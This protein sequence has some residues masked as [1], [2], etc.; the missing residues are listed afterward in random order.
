MPYVVVAV[1]YLVLAALLGTHC[2]D[3]LI[4]AISGQDIAFVGDL[5]LAVI[6][7]SAAIPLA[8]AF[9]LVS[10]FGLVY[11]LMQATGG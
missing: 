6:F 5:V 10:L 11:P 4:W 8:L 9:W 1:A 3:Y 2:V 7:S